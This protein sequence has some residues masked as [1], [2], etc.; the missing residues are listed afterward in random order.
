MF[1]N[2]QFGFFTETKFKKNTRKLANDWDQQNFQNF[3]KSAVFH[4]F[5]W[6]K[7]KKRYFSKF[8]SLKTSRKSWT[9]ENHMKNPEYFKS[10]CD[11]DKTKIF[12][13]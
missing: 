10:F 12:K 8:P 9:T 5:Y 11:S 6:K 7:A 3:W 4:I 2:K 13:K 1:R